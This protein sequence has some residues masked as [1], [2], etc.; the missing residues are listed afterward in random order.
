[1]KGLPNQSSIIPSSLGDG[2]RPRHAFSKAESS[3]TA[4]VC[5]GAKSL[6]TADLWRRTYLASIPLSNATV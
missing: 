1:M 3:R 2:P 6:V 5:I 4:K